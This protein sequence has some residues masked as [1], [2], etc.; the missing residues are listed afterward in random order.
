MT[1]TRSMP[2][3]GTGGKRA[4]SRTKS[5]AT[6]SYPH[7][8]PSPPSDP[9]QPSR[10]LVSVQE[11]ET[12][13]TESPVQVSITVSDPPTIRR[14]LSPGNHHQHHQQWVPSHQHQEQ[15]SGSLLPPD[16]WSL[17]PTH[18]LPTHD[19]LRSVVSDPQRISSPPHQVVE[20]SPLTGGHLALAKKLSDEGGKPEMRARGV[21]GHSDKVQPQPPPP[22]PHNKLSRQLS[23]RGSE[24]PRLQPYTVLNQGH[25]QPPPTTWYNPHHSLLPSNLPPNLVATGKYQHAPLGANTSYPL[26]SSNLE[27][28]DRARIAFEA[29]KSHQPLGRMASAPVTFCVCSNKEKGSSRSPPIP[30]MTRQNSSSDPQLNTQN[31]SLTNIYGDP[32]WKF[33]GSISDHQDVRGCTYGDDPTVGYG[34]PAPH[35]RSHVPL[36]GSH[37]LS[38][39]HSHSRSGSPHN[40]S[41]HNVLMHPGGSLHS[42][43]GPPSFAGSSH[44]IHSSLGGSNHSLLSREGS[45][46]PAPFPDF[47]Q[48]PPPIP[49]PMTPDNMHLHSPQGRPPAPPPPPPSHPPPSHPPPSHP[50]PS[51]FV[52][53]PHPEIL[54]SRDRLP[55]PLPNLDRPPPPLPHQMNSPRR[56]DSPR[57]PPPAPPAMAM[58]PSDLRYGLYY[59]LCGL[60]SE[61]KV[62]RVMSEYPNESTA[63][64]LCL[65]LISMN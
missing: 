47:S 19:V 14:S 20:D 51:H 21:S 48:P 56:L 60:F 6:A 11:Q 46:H 23:L 62:R 45:P 35:T 39:P 33:E 42:L 17:L 58:D 38:S 18:L 61:E 37:S 27:E 50:P 55:P 12:S 22:K 3:H 32:R 8:S 5:L 63:E 36:A 64:K 15:V 2:S 24:D 29:V 25:T 13:R 28:K 1:I 43:H 49:P 30:L 4:L 7:V 26:D 59:H 31:E 65:Y 41:S 52:M 57:R 44:S 10:M 53:P 34:P 40:G 9:N 54:S 16:H